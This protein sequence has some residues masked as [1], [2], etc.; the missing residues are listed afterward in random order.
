VHTP[1]MRDRFRAHV[2]SCLVL[3]CLILSCLAH[4]QDS[5]DE[6]EP[7]QLSAPKPLV[8][9]EDDEDDWE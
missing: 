7:P 2:L 9:S 1:K 8:Q 4:A 5:E 3:S 6:E